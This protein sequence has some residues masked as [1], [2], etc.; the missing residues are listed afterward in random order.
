MVLAYPTQDLRV[1]FQIS[2]FQLTNQ[3][4]QI[5]NLIISKTI[6][7]SLSFLSKLI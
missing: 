1:S 6:C 4:P 3:L 5:A 2:D 7:R